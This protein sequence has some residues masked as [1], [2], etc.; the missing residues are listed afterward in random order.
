MIKHGSFDFWETR[1]ICECSEH[2]D[3]P[4]ASDQSMNF[5]NTKSETQNKQQAPK[6]A[7]WE[8][9]NKRTAKF[10]IKNQ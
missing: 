9:K 7:L 3:K 2:T 6:C 1:H 8:E 10:I 4:R 5:L